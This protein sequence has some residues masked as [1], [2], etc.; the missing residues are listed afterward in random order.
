MWRNQEQSAMEEKNNEPIQQNILKNH[1]DDDDSSLSSVPDSI[2]SP[3]RRSIWVSV[4][5]E[6]FSG[7]IAYGSGL[8]PKADS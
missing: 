3:P 2:D 1:E 8:L 5:R 7:Q 4:P 6:L